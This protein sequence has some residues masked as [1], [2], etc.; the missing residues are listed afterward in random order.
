MAKLTAAEI[1]KVLHELGQRMLLE[2]GNPYRA[3]AYSRAAES[4]ALSP[5]PLDQLVAEGRLK[6]IPGVGDALA[7]VIAKLHETG[8]HPALEAKRA[9]IPTSVLEMLRIPG[10]PPERVRK[11]YTD[12]GIA[13]ISEL[14][15]AARSGRLQS[16]TGVGAAFQAKVLQGIEISRG[17]Q[18][19]HIHRAA[20]AVRHAAAELERTHPDWTMI[21]PAGEFRRGCELVGALPFV[22][23]DPGLAGRAQTI[24]AADQ[25]IIHVTSKDAY[26]ITLLL[27]T[28]SDRHIAA[29]R[30]LADKSGWTLDEQGLRGRG[31]I[32]ARDTE[33]DIYAALGLP[34]IT[35]ELRENGGEVELALEG[36][37]PELVALKDI[38]GVL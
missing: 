30:A 18:G 4:L 25:L 34:F 12:L 28:G 20:A 9:E 26:G 1:S 8:R 16:I 29:L 37:L 5:A 36:K 7:A 21:T 10:L 11:L 3:R 32:L 38:R 22:A 15:E 27:A 6:E 19:R 23:V 24:S 17:P 35:P 31:R 13:S 14:E 33:Q 2:D